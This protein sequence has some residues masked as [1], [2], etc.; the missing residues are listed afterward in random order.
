MTMYFPTSVVTG[1]GS[2]YVFLLYA[3]QLVW[4]IGSASFF[5]AIDRNALKQLSHAPVLSSD[6]ADQI[7]ESVQGNALD[8]EALDMPRAANG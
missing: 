1:A 2:A 7:P 8:A 4:Q 6:P 5:L 3:L